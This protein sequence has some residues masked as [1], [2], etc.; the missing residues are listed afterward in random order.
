MQRADID[1]GFAGTDAT[2][3]A[4]GFEIRIY[5]RAE[6][7]ILAAALL[8][9][10]PQFAEE[11]AG[12]LERAPDPVRRRVLLL[13]LIFNTRSPS[14]T[15]A[16]NSCGCSTGNSRNESSSCGSSVSALLGN[17]IVSGSPISTGSLSL[18]T[19]SARKIASQSPL[20]FGCTT[21]AV[22]ASP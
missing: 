22:L 7:F 19:T 17:Q 10:P 13:D 11:S 5:Q 1:I 20:G 9:Q 2:R 3:C 4:T 14:R 8:P 16:S 21:N 15:T 6:V 12:H 18:M